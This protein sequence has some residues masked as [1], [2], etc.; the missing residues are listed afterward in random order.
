MSL[1]SVKKPA[2]FRQRLAEV[3][4][5]D[6]FLLINSGKLTEQELQAWPMPNY[7]GKD[8]PKYAAG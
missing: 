8:W 6:K 1:Q 3:I 5:L 7:K 4:G 2:P